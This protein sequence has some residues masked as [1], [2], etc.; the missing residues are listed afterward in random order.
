MA[1]ILVAKRLLPSAGCATGLIVTNAWTKRGSVW[2]VERRAKMTAGGIESVLG[3]W[4]SFWRIRE[5][6]KGHHNYE[7]GF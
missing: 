5:G 7:G 6:R 3:I 2:L 1:R 4:H